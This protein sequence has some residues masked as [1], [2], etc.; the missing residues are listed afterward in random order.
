[1]SG[2]KPV[3]PRRPLW[4]ELIQPVFEVDALCCPK[5]GGRLRVLSVREYICAAVITEPVQSF[6]SPSKRRFRDLL[7]FV[8][9]NGPKSN[10]PQGGP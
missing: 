3:S 4:A 9:P 6:E 1:M 8:S 5:C 10:M 7:I 2:A